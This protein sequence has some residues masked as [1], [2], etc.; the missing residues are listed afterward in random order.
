MPKGAQDWSLYRRDSTTY[1]LQD[2][3]ELAA[4]LGSIVTFDR[5]GDVIHIE[6][7][8]HGYSMWIPGIDGAG[9]NTG[10]NTSYF[11]SDGVSLALTAG[12]DEG[13]YT[14]VYDS[15]PYPGLNRMGLEIRFTLAAETR[16]FRASLN[17]YDGTLLHRARVSYYPATETLSYEDVNGDEQPIATDLTLIANP[18]HFHVLKFVTDLATRSYTRAILNDTEYPLDNP[19][20]ATSPS[21]L[22]AILQTVFAVYAT[23]GN[24]PTIYIDNAIVTQD[25]P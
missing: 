15:H 20:Y 4:R 23:S 24:N 12:S 25:E 6:T 11:L 17:I 19:T 2:L 1:S 14:L 7:F 8:D 5:R 13:R 18:R 21:A 9:G 22:D 16:R 3:A 10:L